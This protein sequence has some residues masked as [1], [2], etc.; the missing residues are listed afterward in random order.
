MLD[1]RRRCWSWPVGQI[2]RACIELSAA[3]L[4]SLV[5][6]PKT[7]IVNCLENILHIYPSPWAKEGV[8][9]AGV[10]TSS[11]CGS[12]RLPYRGPGTPPRR[13][14]H[15]LSFVRLVVRARARSSIPACVDPFHHFSDRCNRIM[16]V[17][18][19][20]EASLVRLALVYLTVIDGSKPYRQASFCRAANTDDDNFA[21]RYHLSKVI[22]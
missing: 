4:H 11:K 19:T 5:P 1:G 15:E 2:D 14:S 3:T 13:S 20:P 6:R 18:T 21:Q 12:C 7:R 8:R 17:L 16:A 9:K 10:S 22:A